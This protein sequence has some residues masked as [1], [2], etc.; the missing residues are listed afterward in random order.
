LKEGIPVYFVAGSFLE[1]AMLASC[2]AVAM[3]N[4]QIPVDVN[5]VVLDLV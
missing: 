4:I 5:Q 2:P 3:P 1:K